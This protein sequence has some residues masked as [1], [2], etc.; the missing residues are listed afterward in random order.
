MVK[1]RLIFFIIDLTQPSNFIVKI[2]KG[3][4]EHV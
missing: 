4:Y 1:A 3:E 2:K